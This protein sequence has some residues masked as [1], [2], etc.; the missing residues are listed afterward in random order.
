MVLDVPAAQAQQLRLIP[1]QMVAVSP[2]AL[3]RGDRWIEEQRAIHG[4]EPIGHPQQLPPHPTDGVAKGALR[5]PVQRL[6]VRQVGRRRH[7]HDADPVG[8]LCMESFDTVAP[9]GGVLGS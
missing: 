2:V 7:V 8:T 6:L 1:G 4:H 3:V 9:R 5:W